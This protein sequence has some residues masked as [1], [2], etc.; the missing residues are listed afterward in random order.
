MLPLGLSMLWESVEPNAALEKRFGFESFAAV[1]DW[2]S[3]TL[4]RTW[5]ITVSECSRM[6]ISGHNAIAWVQTSSGRLV[7]KWSRAVELFPKLDASTQLL[8][9]LGAQGLPVAAPIAALDG[10]ARVSLDGPAGTLSVTVLP[11]LTGDW[12]D[13]ADQSAV[14]AAGASLADIHRALS[15]SHLK[16]SFSPPRGQR[17]AERI[18]DWLA[19]GDRGFAPA[20]SR[21]LAES[22]PQMPKLDD[23][24]QLVH[25]DFR[26]ANI[27]TQGSQVVAVLD[28]DEIAIEHRV[29]DLAQASVY[30][31]TLFRDWGPTPAAARQA[32][33]AGYESIRPLTSAEAQWYDVLVLWHGI[34]AIPDEYDTAGWADQLNR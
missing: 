16:A 17:L 12:L 2:V 20:A 19:E 24:P 13:I 9:T 23:Q 29:H 15:D 3:Q 22:L 5:G 4:A 10:L 33:R 11:E 14:H 7:V 21:Q 25:N 31:G 27:L 26:A 18:A 6:V 28:F 34:R 1:S 32:L 30:L 8:H